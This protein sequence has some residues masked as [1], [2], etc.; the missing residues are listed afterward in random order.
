MTHYIFDFDGVLADSMP[1]WAGTY[2]QMLKANGIPVPGD[3]VRRITPLGNA[4]A[5]RCL[6]E[7]GLQM[8][9][10]EI[11]GFAMEHF[12]Y[13]YSH[14]IPLKPHVAEAL[15]RLAAEGKRLHVLTGSSHCYVEP[16]LKRC[17]VFE[18]FDNIWSVDDFPYTKA[19]PE[20]YIEAA[21]RLGAPLSECMFFD[22]NYGAICAAAK[23]GMPTAAVYDA[24]SADFSEQMKAAADRY[25]TDFS[26][27]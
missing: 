20:I 1:V 4:G 19:Q 5:A 9:E 11:L 18:L 15:S 10:D 12:I 16:C 6:I 27:I 8:P 21:K 22:D 7:A 3:F 23:A 2:V 26:E 14:N 17:G 25:I 24:S 13:E